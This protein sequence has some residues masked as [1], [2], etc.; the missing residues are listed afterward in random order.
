MD[1]S[2]DSILGLL[3]LTAFVALVTSV[4]LRGSAAAQLVS[5]LANGWVGTLKA[6]TGR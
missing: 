6:A 5:A 1:W 3:G 2:P 4:L